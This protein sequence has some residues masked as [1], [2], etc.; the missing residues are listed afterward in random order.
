MRLRDDPDAEQFAAWLLQIGC[1][2]N[3]DENGKV[4]IPQ[5]MHLNDIESLMNFIYPDLN[6]SSPPPPEY[7]LNHIILAPQNFDVNSVNET[8]LDRMIGNVKTYYS[9]DQ[10]LHESGIDDQSHLPIMPEFL[11]AVKSSSLPPGELR[12]KIGCPLI[13]M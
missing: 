11:C 8:L 3:S 10:V 12:I 13:L 6:S 9:A 5:E 2:E 7:F 1:G 4:E